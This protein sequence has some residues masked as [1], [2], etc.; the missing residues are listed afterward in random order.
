[1]NRPLPLTELL[2]VI[3]PRL[4]TLERWAAS[5]TGRDTEAGARMA[6][7]LHRIRLN[8]DALL[9]RH[10]DAIARAREQDNHGLMLNLDDN[11]AAAIDS[12]RQLHRRMREYSL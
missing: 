8:L 4:A 11:E 6:L 7:E 9:Q 2:D 12:A 1:M 10:R 3:L 5:P